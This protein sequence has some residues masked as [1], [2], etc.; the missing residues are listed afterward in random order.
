MKKITILS[1]HLLLIIIGM[2]AHATSL[3]P[4]VCQSFDQN[5]QIECV[6]QADDNA[7]LYAITNTPYALCSQAVCHRDNAD[8]ES[9]TCICPVYHQ[10]AEL[11]DWQKVSVGPQSL[12]DSQP[13]YVGDKLTAVISNFSLASFANPTEAKP[14]QCQFD[15][16]QPWAS[17]FGATCQ[18]RYQDIDGQQVPIAACQCAVKVSS[19]FISLGPAHA[20]QCQR[21]GDSLWAATVMPNAAINK[22]II[23]D[24]YRRYFPN[25]VNVPEP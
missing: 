3:T 5:N 6:Y 10:Q 19:Q 21:E 9:A 2:T 23:F 20:D 15:Q 25:Q 14:T 16:P 18:V 11:A 4:P 8:P 22:A 7:P 17:C 1:T 13:A 12:T 24:M